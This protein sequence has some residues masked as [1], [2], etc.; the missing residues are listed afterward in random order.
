MKK[1]LVCEGDWLLTEDG[2]SRCSGTLTAS[3]T[4]ELAQSTGLSV[5]Q[6]NE[7]ENFGIMM[8]AVAFVVLCMKKAITGN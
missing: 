3:T 5:E 8:F 2:Y 1:V 4:A 7:L 6:R